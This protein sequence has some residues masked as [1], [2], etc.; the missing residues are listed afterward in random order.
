MSL[1]FK[2]NKSIKPASLATTVLG[3]RYHPT[4]I[5]CSIC[6]RPLWGRP[7][8]K[9]KKG[10]TCE[11]PCT[12]APP[13]SIRP[14]SAN[15]NRP[16]SAAKSMPFQPPPIPQNQ[17]PYQQPLEQQLNQMQLNSN[18]YTMLQYYRLPNTNNY[19]QYSTQNAFNPNNTNSLNKLCKVCNQSVFNKRF[20]TYENGDIICQT[21]D[22][23]LNQRPPRVN[24]AHMII[25]SCCN[26]TVRGAKYFTDPNG[27]ITCDNC[28]MIGARCYNC[29]MLFKFREERRKLDNGR[30]FHENCFQCSLCN[31]RITT[32]EYYQTNQGLPM[33]LSCFEISKL[34]KCSK[35][36][37]HISGAYMMIENNAIHDEC[38]KCSEC[39]TQ[40]K[41]SYFKNKLN[42]QFLCSNCNLK[43]NGAK[44]S[45][46]SNVIEKEGITFANKDFHQSCFKCDQCGVELVKMKKTL[47]DKENKN[48]YCEPCFTKSFAPKCAKCNDPITPHLPGTQFEEKQYHKECFACA[49]CKRTLADKRFFKSGNILV[50]E[51]CY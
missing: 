40:L 6:D 16:P 27:S 17:T 33:C 14:P 45:R 28:E 2:C 8:K 10:L 24:S 43:L 37:R 15:K 39:N 32:K 7:F 49:R 19:P 47:T 42:N 3:E 34:P 36:S 35:C 31:N 29:K 11:Q 22:Q 25:C 41:D 26:N 23:T 12:P 51:N 21:C 4:C 13:P 48:L 44:C 18:Q 50:C 20:I 46:C 9:D 30:E 38:F 1:C 5:S